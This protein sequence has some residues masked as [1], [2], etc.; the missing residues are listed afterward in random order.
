MLH[1]VLTLAEKTL[2]CALRVDGDIGLLERPRRAL[3][4]SRGDR[5]ST[6][7]DP[8]IRATLAATQRLI[9]AG[10]VLVA[11]TD[12]HPWDLALWTCRRH[13]GSAIVVLCDHEAQVDFLP[14]NVLRVWPEKSAQPT[15]KETR[16]RQ[17]DRL[18]G[19][20]ASSAYSI[21]IRPGGNMV[22]LADELR[23]RNCAVEM[24]PIN[25]MERPRVSTRQ[26]HLKTQ[27]PATNGRGPLLNHLTHF[28]REP[29]GLWPNERYADFLQWLSSGPIFTPRD[30]FRSLRR[31]LAAKKISACG[32]LISGGESMVCLTERDPAELLAA[33]QWRKGLQRWTYSNYALSF[34]RAALEALGARP[35]RYAATE[36][37]STLPLDKRSFA[38][39]TS[40]AGIDWKTEAEWRV[41]GDLD[42]SRIDPNQITAWVETDA[43]AISL[44]REFQIQALV[45]SPIQL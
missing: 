1:P 5:K 7:A 23:S 11:G 39:I 21:Q 24:W 33:N 45:I 27:S 41:R 35:V 9:E 17:R 28:T 6:P 18:V 12:R 37:L 32:R 19:L 20:L 10:E 22:Q 30:A 44:T 36:Q 8:R 43:E 3:L 13:A 25:A 15:D 2:G 40:S 14:E 31:I 34:D 4:I 38:Q 29:D 16:L 26:S 42:F